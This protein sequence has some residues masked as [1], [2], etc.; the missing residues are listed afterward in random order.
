MTVPHNSNDFLLKDCDYKHLKISRFSEDVL[1]QS[2]EKPSF[3]HHGS[4][5]SNVSFRSFSLFPDYI[6]LAVPN[7]GYKLCPQKCEKSRVC[8]LTQNAV[9]K[10]SSN[11]ISFVICLNLAVPV[12]LCT[13]V[14]A[15]PPYAISFSVTSLKHVDSLWN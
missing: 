9:W 5:V 13:P 7:L 12:M 3:Q 15:S 2:I 14:S 4:S 6:P 1:L 8:E 11:T 10:M